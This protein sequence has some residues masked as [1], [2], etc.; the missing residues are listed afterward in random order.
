MIVSYSGPS[1]DAAVFHDTDEAYKAALAS[2]HKD[3]FAPEAWEPVTDPDTDEKADLQA[4]LEAAGIA[5]DKRFGIAKLREL[6]ASIP[7][8]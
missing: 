5:F 1:A 7:Q 4:K 8:E 3:T 2:G 6:V